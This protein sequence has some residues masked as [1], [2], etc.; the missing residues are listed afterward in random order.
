MIGNFWEDM[1]EVVFP[2]LTMA[3]KCFKELSAVA[4]GEVI[5]RWQD[6]GILDAD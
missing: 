1:R 5:R 4:K 6:A 2:N 3:S